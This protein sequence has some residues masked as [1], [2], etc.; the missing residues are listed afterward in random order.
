MNEWWPQIVM[1]GELMRQPIRNC[2]RGN[3]TVRLRGLGERFGLLCLFSLI[4]GVGTLHASGITVVTPSTSASITG[5]SE[6]STT[7]TVTSTLN[8]GTGTDNV[9]IQGS[10]VSGYNGTW[11]V[12]S[13]TSSQFQFTA[14]S[15]IATCSTTCGTASGTAAC[16]NASGGNCT[17]SKFTVP[18]T[19]LPAGDTYILVG[20]SCHAGCTPSITWS[21]GSANSWSA[22]GSQA[23]A[24]NTTVF[25]YELQNPTAATNGSIAVTSSADKIVAGAVLLAGVLTGGPSSA[26]RTQT[27]CTDAGSNNASGAFACKFDATATTTASVTGIVTNPGD[28]IVDAVAPHN[29]GT[30]CDSP[31]SGQT[32]EWEVQNGASIT[33]AGDGGVRA[34]ISGTTTTE[35]WTLAASTDWAMGA[36][37]VI[38][39]PAAGTHPRRGQTIVGTL[40]P[41]QGGQPRAGSPGAV[42]EWEVREKEVY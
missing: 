32:A 9:L 7:V 20:V 12:T 34:I 15:G 26:F 42:E 36:I 8:P 18:S 31:A 22:L 1:K 37:S 2:I 16:N 23:D 13:S 24:G 19:G 3:A 25:I 11:S 33:S 29:D 39:Q 28:M 35:S 21:G 40:L 27:A 38:P 10:S 14:P 17:I 6:A 4:L 30:C 41:P 5:I